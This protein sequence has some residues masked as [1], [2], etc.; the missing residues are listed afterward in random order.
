MKYFFVYLFSIV[1]SIV[2]SL[3]FYNSFKRYEAE[4]LEFLEQVKVDASSLL[5][6]PVTQNE[7][8]LSKLVEICADREL[9][10]FAAEIHVYILMILVTAVLLAIPAIGQLTNKLKIAHEKTVG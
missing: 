1:C 7:V 8:K 3:K 5:S 6:D 9:E 10:I 2:L 4:S